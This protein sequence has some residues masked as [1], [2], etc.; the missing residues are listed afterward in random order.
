[1]SLRGARA[2]VGRTLQRWENGAREPRPSELRRLAKN[3]GK[4]LE[5]SVIDDAESDHVDLVHMQL[6]LGPTDRVPVLAG[7]H[8]PAIRSAL[9]A[10][11][12]VEE[13]AVVVGRVAAALRGA[14]QGLGGAT[15]DL[16]TSDDDVIDVLEMLTDDAGA[17][18]LG[19]YSSNDG[20][21]HRQLLEVEAGGILSLTT[22]THCELAATAVR[23]R[24]HAI[25][26]NEESIGQVRVA[27]AEDLL[28]LAEASRW[29]RD[30]PARAG[31]SAILA[32]GRYSSRE[33][34]A[35]DGPR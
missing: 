18:S 8:W 32:S 15:V 23:D 26:L 20:S 31:L 11:A 34:L 9:V 13:R 28:E 24:A 3:V 2:W 22:Q 12:L 19:V 6:D 14:P 33:A 21:R 1:M 5:I 35:G 27:L 17:H 4:R 30:G 25:F 29:S 16:L 7:E 10:A